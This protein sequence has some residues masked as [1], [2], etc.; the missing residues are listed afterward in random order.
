MP[1]YAKKDMIRTKRIRFLYRGRCCFHNNSRTTAI[2]A[3]LC[4]RM[5]LQ[6]G[7]HGSKGELRRTLAWGTVGGCEAEV[8]SA[9]SPAEKIPGSSCFCGENRVY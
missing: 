5:C 6:V 7:E 4:K 3:M 9:L 8:A 2:G 1:V